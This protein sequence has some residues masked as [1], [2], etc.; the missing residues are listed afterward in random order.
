MPRVFCGTSPRRNR[1]HPP[2]RCRTI[3]RA[4]RSAGSFTVTATFPSPHLR[5]L[6]ARTAARWR[7]TSFATT[8]TRRY[9]RATHRASS[10]PRRGT[11]VQNSFSGYLSGQHVSQEL[12]PSL[13]HVISP[14][15]ESRIERKRRPLRQVT[16]CRRPG[17]RPA[18]CSSG[19][20]VVQT[21]G[22]WRR[23]SQHLTQRT[24][25]LRSQFGHNP[26]RERF[27]NIGTIF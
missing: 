23:T 20:G 22:R 7:L 25:L 11:K 27:R 19:R 17:N 13:L 1:G 18:S 21:D 24:P 16:S 2:P 3:L 9:P 6:S 4:P 8:P 15:M 12:R 26:P 14:G 10:S 5:T